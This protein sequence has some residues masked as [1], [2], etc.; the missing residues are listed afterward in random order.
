MNLKR[1]EEPSLSIIVESIA[2]N[3]GL[4]D[5]LR[6]K[7]RGLGFAAGSTKD[8][9]A[10]WSAYTESKGPN[11]SPLQRLTKLRESRANFLLGGTFASK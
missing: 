9:D 7:L 6:S 5:R 8:L 1:L 3:E 4:A 2:G 10:K 11:L